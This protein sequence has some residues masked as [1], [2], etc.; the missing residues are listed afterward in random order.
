[1]KG[2]IMISR[3]LCTLMLVIFSWLPSILGRDVIIEFK[4]AYFLA[5]GHNFKE[6]YRDGALYGPE[7]TVQLSDNNTCWSN[8]YG[9]A[10]IDFLQKKGKSIGLCNP[11]K[12]RLIPLGFGLKYFY[13]LCSERVD[14]YVGLGFQP[15]HVQ[16]KN[17]SPYVI[18]NLS[19]WGFGGIAKAGAYIDL[20]CNFVLDLFINYS[21]VKT[22]KPC[23]PDTVVPL[24]ANVS[25]V[26]FGG[27][28]G[29]RF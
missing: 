24:A 10:S 9:F 16:T 3:I 28:L 27:G 17:D 20:T 11:T 26:I 2:I 6:I 29:Y 13:P 5:T 7:L 8:F 1:M 19:K 14:L 18:E 12:V 25:G 15:V 4:G 21:F 22:S 23:T